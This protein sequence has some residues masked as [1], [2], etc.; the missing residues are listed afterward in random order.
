MIEHV[1]MMAKGTGPLFAAFVAGCAIGYVYFTGL[2]FTVHSLPSVSCPYLFLALSYSLRAAFALTGFY[3]IME[4]SW[5]A[6]IFALVGFNTMRL[7]MIEAHG[8]VSFPERRS[9][10]WKSWPFTK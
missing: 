9:F 8:N 1:S 6:L 7:M 3:V 10:K 5:V 2:L 4:G